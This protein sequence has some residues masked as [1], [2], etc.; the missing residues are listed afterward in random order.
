MSD[1]DTAGLP[2]GGETIPS[3][4]TT[5]EP[6]APTGL[7]AHLSAAIETHY[8][9]DETAPSDPGPAAARER[10][11]SGRFVAKN[12]EGEAALTEPADPN[13]AEPPVEEPDATTPTTS[14]VEA[15]RNFTAEQKQAFAQLPPEAQSVLAGIEKAREAEYTR[16]NQEVAEIK[17]VAE[18]IL[19]KVQPH[20]DYLN[21]M[22]QQFGAQPADLIGQ[23]IV[24][25]RTLRT[26]SPQQK[27]EALASIIADYGLDLSSITGNA[28]HAPD[29]VTSQLR[30]ELQ[31][32]RAELHGLK[33]FAQEQQDQAV[34][35]QIEQFSSAKKADGS[36]QY[37]HF[38]LV[39]A[40]MG[41]HLAN[42]SARTM[43]EAYALAAKPIEDRIAGEL[44]S[45]TETAE[46]ARQD[47]LSKARRAAPVRSSGSVP[48]GTST[49]AKGLDAI[50]AENISRHFG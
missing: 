45:R 7:D 16:R 27:A 49:G 17:R 1:Q 20:A 30:Q 23:M 26:G 50:L 15:P 13:A 39:K 36:P 34:T 25:E 35:S 9:A 3:A 11:A 19:Q 4:P 46:K 5:T 33:T 32:V 38:E 22:A 18:P 41:Q 40:A 24:A 29:P 12:A 48:G 2:A 14:A 42:G 28:A 47:Q 21:H 10:D 43:E 8:E 6:Q 44:R 31:T 37:P